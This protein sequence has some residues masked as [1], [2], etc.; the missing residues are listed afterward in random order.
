MS[1]ERKREINWVARSKT[2]LYLVG[3]AVEAMD[4]GRAAGAKYLLG[5][6]KELLKEGQ[7]LPTL[8]HSKRRIR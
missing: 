8:L 6:S 3:T 1:A 5:T 2:I 4:K 7:A